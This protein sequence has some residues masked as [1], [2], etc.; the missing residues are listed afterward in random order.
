[1]RLSSAVTLGLFTLVGT[2][3]AWAFAP[4]AGMESHRLEVAAGADA[5]EH[6]E[7]TWK[8]PTE[9][10]AAW[11][12]FVRK[13]G[14]KWRA[15]WDADTKVPARIYGA[16][17]T[18]ADSSQKPAIAA[19]AARTAIAQHLD[20]LAPG[21]NID[22][23]ELVSNHFDAQTNLRTVGFIQRH[24][25][26]EVRGG[27]VNVRIK[28]DR[29]FVF[30]SA[31]LPNVGVELP[32]KRKTVK[33]IDAAALA[34][35]D[36]TYDRVSVR[37]SA[38]ELFILPI[39]RTSGAVTYHLVR[40]VVVDVKSPFSRWSVYVDVGS[41]DV[42]A[43]EQTL[44]FAA[45]TLKLN[46]PER[47]PGDTRPDYLAPYLRVTSGGQQVETDAMGQFNWNGTDDLSGTMTPIGSEVRVD[48]GAGAR[49]TFDFTIADGGEVVWDARDEE[50]ID[51]QLTTFIH[52]GIAK[53]YTKIVAP[54]L[55]WLQ[56]E[57]L[58]ATVNLDNTCNA[59]SDGTTINFFR[60][61]RQCDNTGRLADVVHHEFGH[62]FHAHVV[63]RGVGAF[64]GA[65]SEGAS[66]YLA[67][68]ITNDPGMGR[69][70][71]YSNQPLRHIDPPNQ[72]AVWPEDI[73][74]V[75][76]TGLIFAG[77]LWD[78]RKQLVIDFGD[79]AQAISHTDQLW[80]SALQRSRD[81][82][83]SYVEV[84]AADD[85]D[86]DL[87]NGTPNRCTIDAAFAL[88]GLADTELVGPPIGK[89]Q[90]DTML[91]VYL[92]VGEV[93]NACPGAS[94]QSVELDWRVRGGNDA[95]VLPMVEN[96]MGY[97]E[98]IPSQP[99]GTVVQ[100]QV[101]VTLDSGDKV[102]LPDNPADP[103]YEYFIGE[104]EEIY[105]TSYEGDPDAE[106]WTHELLAGEQREGADDWTFAPPASPQ[107][108][109]DPTEAFS[110]AIVAGNDL[111]GGNYNGQYQPNKQNILRAPTLPTRDFDVVRLQYYRWLTVEDADF[112]QA[113]IL[114]NGEVVW[115]N[116][117]T[118]NQGSTHHVDKEWRFHDVDV[119][120]YVRNGAVD[121]A[122]RLT[123]DGGLQMG[124]WTIDDFCF[125]GYNTSPEAICGN[126]VVED[127][128]SCDDGNAIAGDGCE[129]DCSIT[130]ITPACGD[131]NLDPGEVCDDGNQIAGDG[132]E[133]NCTET[134]TTMPQCPGDPSCP[135][136]DPNP[137]DGLTTVDDTGCGC[138]AT[139]ERSSAAWAFVLLG[140]LLFV[141]RRR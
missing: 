102:V 74:E 128:E 127:G 106:G 3:A 98:Q 54:N 87:S 52:G 4:P 41:G 1:M 44:M 27:N 49:A 34:H 122:F 65:L 10:T 137:N 113:E 76:T 138:T 123:T 116:Y 124:G 20:L 88:H 46:T 62:S 72:E 47:R 92:P 66:D 2:S 31:A 51:A 79:E 28:N 93:Q 133:L 125:V 139:E 71:F 140:A 136:L 118:G 50:F 19:D 37:E 14:D 12:R 121:I 115:A 42:V 109:G 48:N 59:F 77:A 135:S 117:A 134:V 108:S 26:F 16:G 33:A 5:R 25:G 7:V 82:P 36:A 112:D 103:Y 75:H 8:V 18:F 32:T 91:R 85:D 110:G 6:P 29:M 78:L 45:G 86:G 95:G 21:S 141:R 81:I 129:A 97:A 9:A 69:G 35:V 53:E 104:A 43:R 56:N 90:I 68:T 126:G 40:E 120:D 13:N 57:A 63:I 24:R 111:G 58:Q 107:G 39:I 23:F 119:T 100:Y 130:V 94:I 101:E 131:G 84:L 73:G 132:C 83:T 89:P 70:F 11:S 30:G 114:A 67:A 80:H 17:R 15:Q 105:C 22:D 38:G 61:S 55:G 60:A 96:Q 99:A 64:D